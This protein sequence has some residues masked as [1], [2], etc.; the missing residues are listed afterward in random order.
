MV[1]PKDTD[2]KTS[3]PLLDASSWTKL[4]FNL[5]SGA[6]G[7]IFWHSDRSVVTLCPPCNGG[8]IIGLV[9][10]PRNKQPVP[11]QALINKLTLALSKM[12]NDTNEIA[13]WMAE[14]AGARSE[15]T[16]TVNTSEQTQARTSKFMISR[17]LNS[18][19]NQ[20][21]EAR[22][23]EAKGNSGNGITHPGW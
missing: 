8:K 10:V 1:S 5:D 6:K 7:S 20:S 4:S 3:K 15:A 16:N 14:V 12:D 22:Q 21:V 13:D 19:S 9:Q 18:P 23:Q 2:T 11:D 17:T